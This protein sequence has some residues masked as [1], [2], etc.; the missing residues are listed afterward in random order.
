M[1][2]VLAMLSVLLF[3]SFLFGGAE[4]FDNQM[5]PLLES[6]LNIYEILT[7][8]KT[9]G[10]S[11]EAKKLIQLSKKVDPG[12]VTG[13]HKA[14]YKHVPMNISKSAGMILKAKNIQEIREAFKKLSQPFS[15]W[16]SMSKPKGMSVVYCG[17]AKGSWIQKKGKIQNPY[18]RRMPRCGTIVGGEK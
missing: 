4:K 12:S 7:Q 16:V 17:M 9:E 18:D 3:F 8:D 10:I 11:A 5:K 2:K 15:M 14:H 1:K 13:E 6:Y